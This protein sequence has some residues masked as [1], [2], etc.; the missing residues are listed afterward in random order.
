MHKKRR[1]KDR[2]LQKRFKKSV[3]VKSNEKQYEVKMKTMRKRKRMQV[4]E[5]KNMKKKNVVNFREKE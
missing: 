4:L 3:Y 2:D 5:K 1:S